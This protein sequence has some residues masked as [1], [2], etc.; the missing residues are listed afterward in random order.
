M[1]VHDIRKGMPQRKLDRTTFERRYLSSFI[2]SGLAGLFDRQKGAAFSRKGDPGL[3][4]PEYEISNG[5]RQHPAASNARRT[6]RQ[7]RY[8]VAHDLSSSGLN[9][10]L[11]SPINEI[12][13]IVDPHS[14]DN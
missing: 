6:R 13:N 7:A 1:A 11:H 4:D 2:E 5:S 3:A 14:R 12:H 8:L 9:L 10:A